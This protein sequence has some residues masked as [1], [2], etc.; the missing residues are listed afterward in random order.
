LPTEKP[1]PAQQARAPAP[2][3]LCDDRRAPLSWLRTKPSS[4]RGR[5]RR[6][7]RRTK[8]PTTAIDV[9]APPQ[10]PRRCGRAGVRS[11]RHDA[12]LRRAC[13]SSPSRDCSMTT[14]DATALSPP[15][16]T[17]RRDVAAAASDAVSMSPARRRYSGRV[18]IHNSTTAAKRRSL[19]PCLLSMRWKT[20]RLD[21]NTNIRAITTRETLRH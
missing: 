4:Y 16:A 11:M 5:S 9:S 3:R 6:H 1:N 18:P 21:S 12:R 2:G 19:S 7:T 13:A 8:P 17:D 14:R 20:D 10:L 15:H